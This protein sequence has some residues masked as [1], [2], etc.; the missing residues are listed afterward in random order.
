MQMTAVIWFLAIIICMGVLIVSRMGGLLLMLIGAVFLVKSCGLTDQTGAIWEPHVGQRD[1]GERALVVVN[2]VSVDKSGAINATIYNGSS[3]RI[4]SPKLACIVGG[5]DGKNASYTNPAAVIINPKQVLGVKFTQQ[6]GSWNKD[7]KYF[8][9]ADFDYMLYDGLASG[10]V[11]AY[12]TDGNI[13][14]WNEVHAD[15]RYVL[16]PPQDTYDNLH[17]IIVEGNV[18]NG[19]AKPVKGVKV[20]CVFDN[21]QGQYWKYTR[22]LP[23]YVRN[24]E[25]K[26]FS[27]VMNDLK[28]SP[29]KV[30]GA[31]GS[32]VAIQFV[33]DDGT[34]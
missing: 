34:D 5:P 24:G 31:R 16:D 23:V 19:S 11:P 28:Y 13:K 27:G 2:N 14:V 17:K 25:T 6:S 29:M 12:S 8:C 15:V 18:T 7:D 33:S 32:C 9:V 1:A 22:V 4:H 3:G 26:E 20:T 10:A 30:R 21:P